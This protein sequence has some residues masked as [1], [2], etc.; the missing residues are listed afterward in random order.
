[1]T[2]EA[3]ERAGDGRGPSGRGLSPL[4]IALAAVAALIFVGGTLWSVLSAEE[5]EIEDEKP[6]PTLATVM[7]DSQLVVRGEA[8]TVERLGEPRDAGVLA[9][10]A[11][12]EVLV[13]SGGEAPTEL[14]IY[15]QDFRETWSEGQHMLLF[16][17]AEENLPGDAEL[18]VRERCILDEG[19]LPCPY[20]EADIRP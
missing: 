11:V 7:N 2:D 13:S 12:E 19:G 5:A 1:M 14:R 3:I 4:G 15:D 9:T 10:V 16:L 20:D 18:Q 8:T 17:G 6:R